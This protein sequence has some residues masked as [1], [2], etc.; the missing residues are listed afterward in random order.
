MMRDKQVPVMLVL[1]ENDKLVDTD[2]S[3]EL[4]DILGA[5]EQN[6]STYNKYN[7]LEKERQTNSFPWIVVLPEGGHYSFKKH[8]KLVNESVAEF[9]DAVMNKT[10][11]FTA[12][13]SIIRQSSQ[14][15]L[16]LSAK[17][18]EHNSI[19]A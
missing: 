14:V 10:S 11:S 16:V 1:S 6:I 8:P 7:V 4:A 18:Q 19:N 15:E 2:I 12:N 3:Y 9:M 5:N 13:N 17:E